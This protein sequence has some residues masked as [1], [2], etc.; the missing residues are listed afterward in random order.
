MAS[1]G[2]APH[3]VKARFSRWIQKRWKSLSFARQRNRDT[4]RVDHFAAAREPI[5]EDSDCCQVVGKNLEPVVHEF[6]PGQF[7]LGYL[8]DVDWERC[9]VLV[10]FA[11]HNRPPQWVPVGKVRPHKPAVLTREIRHRTGVT[12]ALRPNSDQPYVFQPARIIVPSAADSYGGIGPVCVETTMPGGGGVIRKFVHPVQVRVVAD[13]PEHHHHHETDESLSAVVGYCRLLQK[14]TARLDSCLGAATIDL[15]HLLRDLNDISWIKVVRIKVDTKGIHCVYTIHKPGVFDQAYLE[16][17]VHMCKWRQTVQLD[18]P[19]R[20]CST[21]TRNTNISRS[22]TLGMLPLELHEGIMLQIHDIHS[23]VSVKK[24]CK[25]WHTILNGR[26]CNPHVAV[27]LTNLLPNSSSNRERKYSRTH[28]LNVLDNVVTAATVSLTLLNG[29]LTAELDLYIFQFLSIKVT[30]LPIIVLKNIRCFRSLAQNH[31]ERRLK[32]ANL[33][34]LMQA[35][36]VLRLRGVTIPSLF[37]PIAGLWCA[38]ADFR[39]D[40]D[41]FVEK[42]A[43]NCARSEADRMWHFLQILNAGCPELP[44]RDVIGINEACHKIIIRKDHRLH[45]RLWLMLTLLNEPVT[46]ELQPPLCRLAA[47]AFR[48]SYPMEMSSNSSSR[49]QTRLVSRDPYHMNGVWDIPISQNSSY[50]WQQFCPVP[51]LRGCH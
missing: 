19:P 39:E 51:V 35:C 26:R 48:Y 38:P 18:S 29:N 31:E 13:Y 11:C 44:T 12:V 42:A 3:S 30:Q 22:V 23:V 41:V 33:S 9:C 1:Q 24:V 28:L 50:N 15:Q 34:Y 46:R 45:D 2:T 27:D 14:Q 4:I 32:W 7:S 43:L 37:G 17:L 21:N 49:H 25:T 36:Q 10:D 20:S 8:C 16:H 6:A 40:V 47:H 5:A